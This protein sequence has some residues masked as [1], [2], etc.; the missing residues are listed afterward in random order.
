MGFET[1]QSR[2]IDELVDGPRG[3]RGSTSCRDFQLSNLMGVQVHKK[4]NI[5]EEVIFRGGW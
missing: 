5:R 3:S 4:E 2:L 1:C